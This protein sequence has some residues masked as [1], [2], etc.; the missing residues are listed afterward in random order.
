[1]AA[2]DPGSELDRR[3]HHDDAIAR[4]VRPLHFPEHLFWVRLPAAGIAQAVAHRSSRNPIVDGSQLA[5]S[6]RVAAG[7]YRSIT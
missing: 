6:R 1:M 4:G 3:V 2:A 5:I 7:P